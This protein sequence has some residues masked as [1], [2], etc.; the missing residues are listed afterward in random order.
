MTRIALGEALLFLAPFLLFAGYLV[1]R[2]RSPFQVA[3]WEGSVSW[4]VVAGLALAVGAFVVTGIT[5][6]RETGAYVPSHL[7]NG[8]VVPGQFR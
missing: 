2:R 1:I 6:E 7:E 8:Q 5:A 3:A 4:L